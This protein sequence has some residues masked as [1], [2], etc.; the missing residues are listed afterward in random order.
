MSGRDDHEPIYAALLAHIESVVK[1]IGFAAT[2][3]PGS[4]I[5]TDVSDT[6]KLFTGLPIFGAGIPRSTLIDSFDVDASTVTLT[7]EAT[8]GAIGAAFQSGFLTTGRRVRPW[9][10]SFEQP[11]LFFR[12]TGD[13][14]RYDNDTLPRTVL[15]GELWLYSRAGEDPDTAPDTALNNLVRVIRE[16]L[17]PDDPDT[18]CFTLGG[19]VHWCRIEGKSDYDPGD[20]DKQ[21]KAVIPVRMLIP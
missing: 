15:E 7:Q 17:A 4:T 6:S 9:T 5:L 12:H 10:D 2:V 3:S 11:A 16:A 14:D 18:N 19:L 8:D 1:Q 13:D 21:S 20:L